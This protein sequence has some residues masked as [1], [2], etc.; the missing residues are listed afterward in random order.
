MAAA[1]K[2]FPA[3][4]VIDITF[5]LKRDLATPRSPLGTCSTAIAKAYHA[6]KYGAKLFENGGLPAFILQGP[7]GSEG[8]AKRGAANIEEVTKEGRA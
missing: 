2:Y 8:G 7:F 5:M 1:R 6:N 3:V 4:D